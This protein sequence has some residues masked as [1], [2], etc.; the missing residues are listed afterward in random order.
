M[1]A[2]WLDNVIGFLDPQAGSRRIRFRQAMNVSLAYEAANTGRRTTGWTS[3]GTSANAEV[4]AGAAITRQ[5][6]R[7]LVRNN[8]L[9]RNAKFQFSTKLVGTGISP[10]AAT[11]NPRLDKKINELWA[12][13]DRTGNADGPGT[14]C[15]M[16]S[17]WAG[18]MFESGEVFIRRRARYAADGFRVPLQIQT[19][20]ADFLDTSRQSADA[21]GHTTDGIIFDV[22][23][24]RV[25][26]H[27][28]N[29]HPGDAA[30]VQPYI[31]S[32]ITPASNIAH[33]YEADRPG[34]IRGITRLASVIRK[35]KD[36]DDLNEA[37]LYARKI[38]AC[39]AVFVRQTDTASGP[40]VGTGSTATD[41]KRI[42]SLEPGMVE[43]LR[44]DEDVSFAEPK[45]AP[46]YDTEVRLWQHE[47]AAG[48]QMP[49]ELLTGDLSQINYSS[50]RGS[51][52]SFRDMIESVRWN[53]FIPT[54]LN[55]VYVWFID[56]CFNAGLIPVQN[57]GVEW[58]APAFDL[59]DRLEEAKADLAELRNGTMT[60][61]QAVGRKG[62]DPAKQLDDIAAWWKLMDAAGVILDCDARQR[63]AQGN[64][65]SGGTPAAGADGK[66][67]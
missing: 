42:E 40:L 30:R 4:S 66:V 6:A 33:L 43:Y 61:P 60:W 50:Y 31:Q 12:E 63:T 15:S 3:G 38:E 32:K 29:V 23:G 47:I 7:D 21:N 9:A 54:A 56:S 18:S 64:I 35:V 25:G 2:N 28:W 49:Y 53:T 48:M 17:T 52:L 59:L 27:M 67:V 57:Y 41:G 19:M 26:Y 58:D 13:F 45:A 39:F 51:L 5:R 22:I 10:R 36:L 44:P 1:K 62:Y 20:E 46:G 37:K 11:G 55:Q 34:Q 14:V 8:P 16:Q 24:N 65:P